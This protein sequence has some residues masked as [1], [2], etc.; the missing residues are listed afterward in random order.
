MHR[1]WGWFRLSSIHI[2]VRL[3]FFI[4]LPSDCDLQCIYWTV[5][6]QMSVNINASAIKKKTTLNYSSFIPL[7]QFELSNLIMHEVLLD[8][9]YSLYLLHFLL[10]IYVWANWQRYLSS[11]EDYTNMNYYN[12]CGIRSDH[13][14]ISKRGEG[15]ILKFIEVR[16][17]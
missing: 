3:V 5:Y 2:Q 4:F 17:Q 7:L 16:L 13:S 11:A 10:T 8:N 14:N 6:M 15:Y 9:N 12:M 1:T